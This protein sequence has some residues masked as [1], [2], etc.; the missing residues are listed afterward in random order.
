MANWL[1]HNLYKQSTVIINTHTLW[2]LKYGWLDR[3]L[4]KLILYWDTHW[5]KRFFTV[6]VLQ[7]FI[8]ANFMNYKIGLVCKEL[9]IFTHLLSMA[10]S[11]EMLWWENSSLQAWIMRLHIILFSKNWIGQSLHVCVLW[12]TRHPGLEVQ[13]SSS[14]GDKLWISKKKCRNET[15]GPHVFSFTLLFMLG[16]MNLLKLLP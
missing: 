9:V 8:Y 12:V 15:Q 13:N 10:V 4:C 16:T 7:L 3:H 1:G 6:H 2:K 14:E 5:W 11:A